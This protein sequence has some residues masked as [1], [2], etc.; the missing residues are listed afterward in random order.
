M[1]TYPTAKLGMHDINAGLAADSLTNTIVVT[2][3]HTH[4]A[5]DKQLHQA[6]NAEFCGIMIDTQQQS[7]IC[8]AA[9]R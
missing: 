2:N 7:C 1:T 8:T 3:G 9:G 6:V 5:G 4:N